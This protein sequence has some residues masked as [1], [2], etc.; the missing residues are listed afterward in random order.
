MATPITKTRVFI[1]FDYDHGDDL[2][3]MLLGQANHHDTPFSFEDWSIKR[4]MKVPL[5]L[6][7]GRKNG[8]CRRPQGTSWPF[9][10]IHGWTWDNIEAMCRYVML[11]WWKR[12]W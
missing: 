6:L 5:W 9:D 11:P 12:I 8:T 2:R 3:R 1:S 4:E 10:P 7:R